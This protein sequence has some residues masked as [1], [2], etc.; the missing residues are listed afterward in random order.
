MTCR[1]VQPDMRGRERQRPHPQPVH[2]AGRRAFFLTLPSR[3]VARLA[4]VARTGQELSDGI[5]SSEG[6]YVPSGFR[7]YN[8]ILYLLDSCFTSLDL[9]TTFRW[10][11]KVEV[12]N[13]EVT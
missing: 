8:C 12:M 2:K 1:D 9:L 4:A 10:K 11:C 6:T 3:R 13:G 5:P 7:S